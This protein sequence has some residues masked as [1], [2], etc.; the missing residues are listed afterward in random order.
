VHRAAAAAIVVPLILATP[1][2][3]AD[4]AESA[5]TSRGE[6][7]LEGR[8]F[9]DDGDPI[10]IDRGFGMFGRLEADHRHG[11]FEE[12]GR[13]FG[14]LD[15][16]DRE[17]TTFVA[18]ELWAQVQ[19]ERLRLRLG[20]DIVNWS[21]LEAFHPVD[22][23]NARNLDSDLENLEKI[24]EPMA[25]LQ[26]QPFENTSVTA[27]FMPV[28]M[29]TLFP[30]PRSR[31][32]FGPP[33]TDLR[34]ARRLL[35]RNGALTDRD[36][37]LQGAV[38]VRQVIK[39]ADLTLHVLENMDRLEPIV[40]VDPATGNVS[41][42][43][44]TVQQIGGTYQQVFGPLIAKLEGAYRHFIPPDAAAVG[45]LGPLPDQTHGIVAAGLEYGLSHANGSQ[46]TFL[47]EGEAVVGLSEPA[48]RALTPFQR[49]VCAAV[50]FAR[51]DEASKELLLV[52]IVDLEQWGEY[53]VSAGYRQRIGETWT[54]NVGLRIF[55]AAAVP[56][57]QATG[58]ELL[59]NGDHVRFSLMRHF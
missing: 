31:L 44:Q 24:G 22:V 33:G 19:G 53:L 58:L 25:A 50:R 52:T 41:L 38:Q 28:Y 6:L 36:F 20:L 48:R 30:S 8:A 23:I 27:M 13:G 54:L 10:T 57:L 2:T 45:Q 56:P 11:R 4:E 40:L 37:G 14:R 21:A 47:L 59:R 49:D 16:F 34:N 12:K 5:W 51:N 29:K 39:S 26:L 3:R 35:D 9:R 55:Q 1:L 15:A 32:N 7:G 17:R 46:S 42:L 18:E 43:F